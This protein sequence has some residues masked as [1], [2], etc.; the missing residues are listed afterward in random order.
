MIIRWEKNKCRLFPG[1]NRYQWKKTIMS[2]VLASK[3]VEEEN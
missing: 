1:K 3:V 2:F